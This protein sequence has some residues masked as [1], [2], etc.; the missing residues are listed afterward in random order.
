[1]KKRIGLIAACAAG[2][3][4]T[5]TP[6]APADESGGLGSGNIKHVLLLSIDGFHAV[7]LQN[8]VKGIPDVNGGSGYCPN[9]AALATYGVNYV[10]TSTSKPSDSFPGLMAIV[11]GGT[12]RTVGA[13]YDVAYDRVLAPP[14]TTTG[15]GCWRAPACR[16]SPTARGLSTRKVSI[17]IRASLM[18]VRPAARAE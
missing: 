6:Y 3:I 1:L 14:A 18:A 17:S 5:S 10:N 2:L 4:A 16:T 13:Y 7:D 15:N 8:C 9:L 12:P 11:T